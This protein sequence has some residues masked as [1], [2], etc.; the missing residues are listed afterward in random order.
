M[1]EPFPFNPALELC[2]FRFRCLRDAGVPASA[3]FIPE[4]TFKKRF[5]RDYLE[6][7]G[8]AA[9]EEAGGGARPGPVTDAQVDAL[10]TQTCL[11]EQVTTGTV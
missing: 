2:C 6:E 11:C 1:E 9:A 10:Y 4:V 7:L 8:V 3:E 5:L